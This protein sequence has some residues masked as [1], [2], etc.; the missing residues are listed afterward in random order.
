MART[1]LELQQI[2]WESA[3]ATVLSVIDEMKNSGFDEG[4]LEELGQRIV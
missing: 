1:E 3:I 2:I 4:T